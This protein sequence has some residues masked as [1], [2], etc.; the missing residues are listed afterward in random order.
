[1]ERRA[2]DSFHNLLFSLT[3]FYEATGSWPEHVTIISNEFKRA[4]FLELHCKALSWP[5]DRVT[6]L[7]IDP[8]YMAQDLQRAESVRDGERRNGFEPWQRDMLGKG[9]ELEAKRKKR[10]P[11]LVKQTLFESDGLRDRS[12][13]RYLI[14]DHRE[15]LDGKPQ[16]WE[17]NAIQTVCLH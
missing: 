8:D 13:I 2:L 10:N 6:F 4:R 9:D 15:V 3:K 17:N 14:L 12:G 11:H 7:G 1:M 5:A 16:S